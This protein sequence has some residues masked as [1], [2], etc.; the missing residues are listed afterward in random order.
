MTLRKAVKGIAVICISLL[1]LGGI[2]FGLWFGIDRLKCRAQRNAFI[3]Q[4]NDITQ[5]AQ[6]RLKVGTGKRD[7]E[8]FFED[9]RMRFTFTDIAGD[10]VADGILLT[11]VCPRIASCTQANIDVSVKLDNLERTK[12][13]PNVINYYVNCW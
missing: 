9:H 6:R 13:E 8:H 3:R 12:E 1:V 7:V 10:S 4:V 2:A 11:K 5:D